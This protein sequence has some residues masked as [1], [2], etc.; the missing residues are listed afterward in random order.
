M[1]RG[2]VGRRGSSV[3]H[4]ELITIILLSLL[5]LGCAVGSQWW[6]GWKLRPS[7]Q[8]RGSIRGCLGDAF[9]QGGLYLFVCFFAS[10]MV[11]RQNEFFMEKN[12]TVFYCL[13]NWL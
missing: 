5:Y 10:C 1:S 3:H 2:R 6:G 12:S 11:V 13:K 9:H 4:S 7:V 8:C